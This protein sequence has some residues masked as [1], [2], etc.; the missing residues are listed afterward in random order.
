MAPIKSLIHGMKDLHMPTLPP[1]PPD[2]LSKPEV[3]GSEPSRLGSDD[4][5]HHHQQHQPLPEVSSHGFHI[6]GN[7]WVLLF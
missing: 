4:D 6:G 2:H 1:L 7:T 3:A 5:T